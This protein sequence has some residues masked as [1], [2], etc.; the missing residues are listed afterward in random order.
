M[1]S[2]LSILENFEEI[3][4]IDALDVNGG[5]VPNSSLPWWLAWCVLF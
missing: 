5:N 3:N 1:N 4:D 2:E